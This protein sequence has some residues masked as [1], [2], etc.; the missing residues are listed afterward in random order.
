M[1]LWSA[2]EVEV[3]NPLNLFTAKP[4]V[5]LVNVSRKN[6]LQ[7][8]NKWLKP[9]KK[10]VKAHSKGSK[11]VPFSARFE[12]HVADIED[13]EERAAYLEEVQV[14]SVLQKIIWAGYKSLNLIHYFTV[15]ED[16]VKCWTIRNGFLA[17]QAA[18]VIHSDF[19][20]GFICANTMAYDD[21]VEYG[22]ENAVKAAG[23]F[24]QNGRNYIVKDG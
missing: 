15:G 22:S 9:I 12:N 8:G 20:K 5:F 18:G 3:V 10:W 21:Y 24:Q 6:W 2:K 19:E 17:P 16:E 1:N 23:K 14:P 7:G 4:V 11:V 13:K